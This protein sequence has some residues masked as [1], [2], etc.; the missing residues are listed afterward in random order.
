MEINA[1]IA[2]LNRLPRLF[3]AA[4]VTTFKCYRETADGGLQEVTVEIHDAG[5]EMEGARYSCV[6]RTND[7]DGKTASGNP[8]DRVEVVLSSVHWWDL[9]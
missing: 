4:H 6:A 2:H 5:P 7:D 8:H 9:D 1:V 3:E